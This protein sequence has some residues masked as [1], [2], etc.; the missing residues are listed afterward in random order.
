MTFEQERIQNEKGQRVNDLIAERYPEIAGTN[1]NPER[2]A[3]FI[4]G[5]VLE[6]FPEDD[7]L[8][9]EMDEGEAA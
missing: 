5:I 7:E 9:Y 4:N 3:E 1:P 8:R 2:I 6:V